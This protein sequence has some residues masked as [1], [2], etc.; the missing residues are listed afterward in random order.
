MILSEAAFFRLLSLPLLAQ[1]EKKNNAEIISRGERV[2]DVEGI[3]CDSK[4]SQLSEEKI[5]KILAQVRKRWRK[6]IQNE[7]SEEKE[8]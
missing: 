2:L 4:I 3:E 7:Y 6:I 8:E 1:E 5:N